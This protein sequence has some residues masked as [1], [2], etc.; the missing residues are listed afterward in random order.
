MEPSAR[1][2]IRKSVS[3]VIPVIGGMLFVMA[4]LGSLR[5]GAEIALADPIEP[6]EGY[7][8]FNVSLKSVTPT[9]ATATGTTLSY[10]IEIRNSGAYT[11]I[12][13]SLTDPIPAGMVYNLDA[14]ASSGAVSFA[15]GTLSWSGDV[16]FDSAVLLDFSVD[17]PS[18][19]SGTVRNSAV[20]SHPLIALPIT[21][22][23]ESVI[24]DYPILAVEKSSEP[25]L[26]GANEVMTYALKVTNRGQPAV[27]LPI[28][29]TDELPADTTLHQPGLDGVAGSGFV[30]WTRSVTLELG[31]STL[32]TFSV[33]VGDVVSGTVIENDNYRVDG[34]AAGI[35]AGDPYTVTVIDPIFS[36]TKSTWPDPPGSNREVTYTLTLFNQG[37]LAT[38]LLI[39]DTIPSG[40]TYVRGGHESAGVVSW[41]LPSLGSFQSAEFTYTVY[42]SDVANVPIVN[43]EFGVCSRFENV[44]QAGTVLT[45]VVQGPIFET[46]AFVEPIAKKPGGKIPVTPTLTVHNVGNGNALAATVVLT[47]YRFSMVNESISA[48]FEDGSE[49]MLPIGPNCLHDGLLDGKCRTFSWT[50]DIDVDETITFT[51][52]SIDGVMST[53]GGAE[54]DILGTGI[55]VT[56]TMSNGEVFTGTSTASSKITHFANVSVI[57]TAPPTI[58]AGQL[59]TYT[60]LARNNGF[61]TDLPPVITDVVPLST[62]VVSISHKG[63]LL[64]GQ[65]VS[66]SAVIAWTLD[67]MGPGDEFERSFTVRIDDDLVSGTQ[68]INQEYIALGYGNVVTGAVGGP[69]VTTTVK[70]IGLIDSYKEVTPTLVAPGPG[71]VLT[72]FVHVVN[73]SPISL[74]NVTVEDLLPWE[75]TTYQ[76]NARVSSGQLISDIVSLHWTG[77]VGAYSE[78]VIT[79]TVLV[80]PGYSGAITN[81][82][83]ISHPDLVEEVTVQAVAYATNDPVLRIS[84]SASPSPVRSGQNLEYTI[85]VTNLGQQA[86]GLVISDTIPAGVTY[87]AGSASSGGVLLVDHVQWPLSVLEPGQSK[88]LFFSVKVGDGQIVINEAYGVS[89][90]EGVSSQGTPVVTRIVGGK[91]FVYLPT[92]L[93]Q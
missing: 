71:N 29:V 13:A 78:E 26:P 27:N 61:T 68:I 75:A 73:S 74:Y 49:L 72:Y 25:A 1:N 19:F 42:I 79:L 20:I 92:I 31:E 23:A 37:S 83:V 6:P 5:P 41:T 69:P 57:K 62:T 89:S 32:F 3:L 22:T 33:H 55:I 18:A 16:G 86:T 77:D 21:V 67:I 66:D 45:S 63:E 7:P 15:N 2:L 28:T 34:G 58:G 51:L 14:H 39:T 46:T 4:V 52:N 9:L 50:G 35:S 43:D 8:K 84:K 11:A 88:D 59:M 10:T 53:I 24:S 48:Y 56:D 12:G 47:Y 17:V 76:R 64:P 60:I 81:T 40:V 44:C 87:V 38:D 90:A 82:A 70:E 80:D 30:T 85:R 93:R 54:G 91:R 36:L 65:T